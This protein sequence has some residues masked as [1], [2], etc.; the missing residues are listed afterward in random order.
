MTNEEFIASI[1]QEGEVWKDVPSYEGFYKA[2]SLG[3]VISLYRV[4]VRKNG[5]QQTMQPSIVRSNDGS[6]GYHYITLCKYGNKFKTPIHRIIALTFLENPENKPVVD[7]INGDKSDNR[8]ENLRWATYSEN[9]LNESTIEKAKL[10]RCEK[11]R[12]VVQ[13]KNN[14]LIKIY[15]Y[16]SETRFDGFTPNNVRKVCNHEYSQHK[17]YQWMYIDEYNEL[18]NKDQSLN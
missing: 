17:G 9:M 5:A 6:S 11:G 14:K 7:H 2:S 4:I 8:L 12:S 16:P 13:L 3:R 18:L 15:Q 10:A 1:S